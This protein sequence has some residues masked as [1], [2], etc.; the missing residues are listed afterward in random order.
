M[1]RHRG[2]AYRNL[3]SSNYSSSGYA[4]RNF[5]SNYNRRGQSNEIPHLRWSSERGPASKEYERYSSSERGIFFADKLCRVNCLIFF[6][7]KGTKRRYEHSGE[8]KKSYSHVSVGLQLK[9][10]Y[11]VML[12]FKFN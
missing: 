6:L 11:L 4:P 1:D 12:L 3:S 7:N 5:D 9:L 2:S 8:Q 10:F